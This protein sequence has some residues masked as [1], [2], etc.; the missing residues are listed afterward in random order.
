MHSLEILHEIGILGAS[1]KL[2]PWNLTWN[3]Q[4][5][6]F[7]VLEDV[8]WFKWFLGKLMSHHNSPWHFV[9]CYCSK[10]IHARASTSSLGGISKGSEYIKWALGRG[11]I[12][13]MLF[14]HEFTW[15]LMQIKALIIPNI[16]MLSYFKYISIILYNFM[17]WSK[18]TSN[19]G[20][21][22]IIK[23]YNL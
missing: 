23:N 8:N 16:C 15:L 10:S 9:Y 18:N 4:I 12:Y 17:L 13:N 14:I 2:H 11:L 7:P 22:Y 1:H 20:L 6:Y 19:Y 3:S 21:L 5:H